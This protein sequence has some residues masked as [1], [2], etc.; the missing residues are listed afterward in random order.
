MIIPNATKVL[1]EGQLGITGP[2][3]NYTSFSEQNAAYF[4]LPDSKRKESLGSPSLEN[5]SGG[6]EATGGQQAECVLETPSSPHAPPL[7]QCPDADSFRM[8]GTQVSPTEGV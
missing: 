7:Y 5:V 2:S 4:T 8:L 3:T 1:A 6:A